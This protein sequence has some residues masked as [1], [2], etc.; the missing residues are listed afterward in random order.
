MKCINF[1]FDVANENYHQEESNIRCSS[2]FNYVCD[3]S[4]AYEYTDDEQFDMVNNLYNITDFENRLSLVKDIKTKITS[5]GQQ[6]KLK[7]IFSPDDFITFK[8]V[9]DL[10]HKSNMKCYYCQNNVKVIYK[11]KRMPYQWTL[12]RI[13][14]S[15]GHIKNNVV[16]SCLHC[17]LKRRCLNSDKYLFTKTLKVVKID[18]I[19]M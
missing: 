4:N 1:D 9:I 15:K 17:N 16:I 6:D 14:N 2:G 12:D 11:Y 5:Y 7:N 19:R 3:I 18:N 8:E 13:D 10:L